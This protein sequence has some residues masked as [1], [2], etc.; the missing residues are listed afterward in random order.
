M[1]HFLLG[2]PVERSAVAKVVQATSLSVTATAAA[3]PAAN[4]A[5]DSSTGLESSWHKHARWAAA[6]SENLSE[7]MSSLS[8]RHLFY[9]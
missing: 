6:R 2:H 1:G 4:L 3:R 5:Q 9:L 7:V 8:N